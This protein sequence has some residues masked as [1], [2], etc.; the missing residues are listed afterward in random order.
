[1]LT[2]Q[3]VKVDAISKDHTDY[4][5]LTN[6]LDFAKEISTD[7]GETSGWLEGDYFNALE[8]FD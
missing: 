5:W 8:F 3:D 4:N 6:G 7:F 2:S 1:M